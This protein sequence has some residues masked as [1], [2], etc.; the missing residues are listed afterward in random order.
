MK[1]LSLACTIIVAGLPGL[2]TA[3]SLRCPGGMVS[4]GDSRLSV[5]YK[6]GQPQLADTYCAPVYYPGTLEVVPQP[7]ASAIVPCQVVEAWLYERGPG[8]LLAT[9]YL[10]SGVVQSINYGREPR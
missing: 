10:R 3:E 1:L 6:C 2:A 4:E 8:N 7:L 9:V 5:I